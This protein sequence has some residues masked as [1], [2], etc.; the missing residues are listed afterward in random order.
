MASENLTYLMISD[1]QNWTLPS[2]LYT[3]ARPIRNKLD[4][5]YVLIHELSPTFIS[6]TESWLDKTSSNGSLS[7]SNYV[8]LRSDRHTRRKGG[9]IS[10][11]IRSE[12]RFSF[13]Y[14]ADDLDFEILMLRLSYDSFDFDF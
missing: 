8:L 5:L 12:F 7:F 2:L 1:R 6:V 13:L 10:I 11:W 9:G 3:N 4:D 14:I